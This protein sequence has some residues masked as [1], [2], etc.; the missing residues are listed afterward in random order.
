MVGGLYPLPTMLE[1]VVKAENKFVDNFEFALMII[2]LN[3]L[4]LCFNKGK[5]LKY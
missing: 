4:E 5:S 1:Y 2:W 3:S